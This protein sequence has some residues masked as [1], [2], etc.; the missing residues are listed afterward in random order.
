MG[1]VDTCT[2]NGVTLGEYHNK[3]QSPSFRSPVVGISCNNAEGLKG[4]GDA[5]LVFLLPCSP[6]RI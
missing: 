6:I 1:W 2:C 4:K 5:D 3:R